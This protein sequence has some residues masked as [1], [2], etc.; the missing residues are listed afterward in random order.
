MTKIDWAKFTDPMVV[1][2]VRLLH[3]I[4]KLSYEAYIVGGAVRD[5]AMGDTDVH[6]IDIAKTCQLM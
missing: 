4:T 5:I 1:S 3:T 6:D 2:G